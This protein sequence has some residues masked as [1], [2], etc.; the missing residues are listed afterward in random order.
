MD[1][2]IEMQERVHRRGGTRVKPPLC[3]SHGS[4]LNLRLTC[5][6][7]EG[8]IKA[9]AP[10]ALPFAEFS[11]SCRPQ[12]HDCLHGLYESLKLSTLTWPMLAPLGK[13]LAHL[14]A[15]LRRYAVGS[16]G[17]LAQVVA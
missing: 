11:T 1:C 7:R 2:G 12:A 13:T 17:G 9:C 14:A 4:R 8:I 10:S 3:T 5:A 6:Q 15:V 16:Q